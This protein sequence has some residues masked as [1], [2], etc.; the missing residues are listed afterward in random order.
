MTDLSL[1]FGT[2][3]NSGTGGDLRAAMSAVQG[4]VNARQ[5]IGR[6]PLAD[7]NYAALPTD[8]YIGLTT[9]TATRT[10]TLPAA[11]AY[12][13]GQTLFIADESG[14]CNAQASTPVLIIIAAAGSDTIAGQ[15]SISMGS[16]YQ[17]LAFHTNGS[18]LWC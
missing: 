3:P 9:L 17:K 5:T 2:G 1:N 18:N 6:V 14:N 12:K 16:P 11:S 7:A 8:T 13:P 10:I 4:A 15:A